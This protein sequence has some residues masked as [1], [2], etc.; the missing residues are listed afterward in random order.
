MIYMFKLEDLL[1]LF[2]NEKT[3]EMLVYSYNLS[4]EKDKELSDSVFEQFLLLK[5]QDPNINIINSLIII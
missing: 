2:S 1:S 4:Q 5:R 3:R